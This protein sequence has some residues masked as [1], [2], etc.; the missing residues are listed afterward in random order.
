MLTVAVCVPFSA[1]QTGKFSEEGNNSSMFSVS[2]P[3][4]ND[5]R[6]NERE[7]KI[8]KTTPRRKRREFNFV[9]NIP[10]LEIKLNISQGLKRFHGKEEAAS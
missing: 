10:P 8:K 6:A 5:I 4:Q 1:A 3:P 2:S 7:L 9:E